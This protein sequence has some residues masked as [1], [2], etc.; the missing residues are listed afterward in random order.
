MQSFDVKRCVGVDSDRRDRAAKTDNLAAIYIDPQP[1]VDHPL[2]DLQMKLKAIDVV[3]VAE[4][5]IGAERREGEVCAALRNVEG[6]AMPLKNCFALGK[7]PQQRILF[8][9]IGG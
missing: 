1:A 7:S 4:S 3:A 6:L 9:M 5:L 8:R 2:I